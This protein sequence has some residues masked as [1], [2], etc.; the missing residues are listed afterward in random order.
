MR[1]VYLKEAKKKETGHEEIKPKNVTDTIKKEKGE[2]KSEN[3][4]AEIKKKA[5][6]P[7]SWR[8]QVHPPKMR[9]SST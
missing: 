6:S 1:R 2:I 8:I 4:K 3:K 5:G 7:R 9:S